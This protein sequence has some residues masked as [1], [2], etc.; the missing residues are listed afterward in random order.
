MKKE[1]TIEKA[2]EISH[3][4]LSKVEDKKL[5]EFL[6]V[7]SS[8]VSET[9]VLIGKIKKLDTEVLEIAGFI[10]D[11]GYSMNEQNH[12]QHS[13]NI[14]KKQNFEISE[15]LKDCIL[16]HGVDGNP[17]TREGEIFQMADKISIIDQD[18]LAVFLRDNQMTNEEK[19]FLEM[20]LSNSLK[21]LA[22][23]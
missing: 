17:K 14:L 5:K 16:N 1:L 8:K 18:T 10:H 22:K 12:S 4:Y 2:K 9:A 3:E 23:L 7:H 11:I 20:M 19:G 13:L 15:K 21:F 6:L